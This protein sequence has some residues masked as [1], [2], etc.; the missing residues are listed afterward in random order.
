MNEQSATQLFQKVVNMNL[1]TS[2]LGMLVAQLLTFDRPFLRPILKGL[3]YLCFS[4]QSFTI[5]YILI[6]G[7]CSLLDTAG[8]SSS[9]KKDIVTL[10]SLL[11]LPCVYCKR[12]N[13]L[14]VLQLQVES[15]NS[16]FGRSDRL[17]LEYAIFIFVLKPT[18]QQCHCFDTDRC[19]K[20]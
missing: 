14:K 19:A 12:W 13:G 8:V 16:N 18:A 3:Q 2:C 9:P 20:F 6:E 10:E 4:R 11:R 15:L 7:A 1:A 17:D 5:A